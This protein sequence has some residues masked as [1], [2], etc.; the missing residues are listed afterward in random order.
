MIFEDGRDCEGAT[1]TAGGIHTK[2]VPPFTVVASNPARVFR[3][4]P[5][6]EA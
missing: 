4:F 6:E 1:I 2:D 5:R 3:E